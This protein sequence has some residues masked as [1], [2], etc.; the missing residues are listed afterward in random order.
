M[1]SIERSLSANLESAARATGQVNQ[2]IQP[3]FGERWPHFPAAFTPG[4]ETPPRR[5]EQKP[6]PGC[7]PAL[8]AGSSTPG[9]EVDFPAGAPGPSRGGRD[10]P[11]RLAPDLF[12]PKPHDEILSFLPRALD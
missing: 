4:I 8:F 1:R 2:A 11:G 5:N 7:V 9:E 10:V 6:L 3:G 12:N